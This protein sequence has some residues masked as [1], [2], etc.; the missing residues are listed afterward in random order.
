[1]PII[2]EKKRLFIRQEVDRLLKENSWEDLSDKSAHPGQHSSAPPRPKLSD[3][4]IID[5]KNALD[6]LRIVKRSLV[7]D[8]DSGEEKIS[9][10][11]DIVDAALA[12]EDINDPRITKILVH[13]ILRLK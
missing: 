9:F 6:D 1:M 11:K 2:D 5:I 10:I 3:L 4:N 13:L 7:S 12:H 8:P